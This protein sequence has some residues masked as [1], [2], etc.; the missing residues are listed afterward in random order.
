MSNVNG[1]GD[2]IQ[3]AV[4]VNKNVSSNT[5]EINNVPL[6]FMKLDFINCILSTMLKRYISTLCEIKYVMYD[7]IKNLGV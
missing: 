5:E 7:A 2:K 1:V 3:N 4:N 6:C